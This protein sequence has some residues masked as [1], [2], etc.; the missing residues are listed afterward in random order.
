MDNLPEVLLTRPQTA[1]V[2]T[3]PIEPG[4]I[5]VLAFSL[6]ALQC[7][8]QEQ[9]LRLVFDNGAI[10][11]L[12][13]F[14]AA[15]EDDLFLRLE[16]GTLLQGRDL[17]HI[18]LL[19]LHKFVCGRD[20]DFLADEERLSLLLDALPPGPDPPA[21]PSPSPAPALS[22][23]SLPAMGEEALATEQYLLSLLS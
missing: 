22:P 5:Y 17:A 21:V 8:V 11:V 23:V 19:D 2:V 20:G 7:D 10:L 6:E 13:G 1:A 12:Q 3:V 15:A 18:F 16:D 4:H 9:S 14:F